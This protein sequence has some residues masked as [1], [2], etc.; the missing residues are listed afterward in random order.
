MPL[1]Y[2]SAVLVVGIAIVAGS[3]PSTAA[4]ADKDLQEAVLKISGALEKKEAAEAKKQA[5]ALAKKTDMEAVM[6]L[7]T[8]RTKGGLG[9]G[10][11]PDE[12]KPDGIEKKLQDLIKNPPAGAQLAG[13]A[14]ALQRMGVDMAAICEVVTALVPD[15][16]DA[17]KK[18]KEWLAMTAE[19]REA[20]LELAAAAKDKKVGPLFQAARKAHASC[21][22]CHEVF[23]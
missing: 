4:D 11:K 10:P 14:A 18:K 6:H 8:P 17:A 3:G 5:S 12:V 22:K 16:G 1:H 19:L 13:E 21:E 9:I 20:G 15:K 7:F 2:R 23:R